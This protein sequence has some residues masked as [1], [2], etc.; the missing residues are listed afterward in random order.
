MMVSKIISALFV[1]F[2]FT[3][4]CNG[5]EVLE[6]DVK[7]MILKLLSLSE[8]NQIAKENIQLSMF[9]DAVFTNKSPEWPW[10]SESKETKK[11]S[12]IWYIK[13]D[14]LLISILYKDNSSMVQ[15]KIP[16]TIR[17]KYLKSEL[18]FQVKTL[19]EI[20]GDYKHIFKTKIPR[21]TFEK[22]IRSINVSVSANDY[23]GD[24]D[25]INC[26]CRSIQLKISSD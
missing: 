9:K 6:H 11:D 5:Q 24:V 8:H 15:G 2:I 25:P 7:S 18:L 19:F 12:S 13:K 22:R 21:L 3:N 10:I 23:F 4:F 26:K 17:F 16:V 1:C 14:N 20:F